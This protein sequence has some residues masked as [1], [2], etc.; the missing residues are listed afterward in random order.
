[1]KFLRRQFLHLAAGAAALPAV[2]RIAG[3]DT[4]P[5][6][7]VRI[8]VGVPAGGPIDLSARLIGQWLSDRL[9]EPFVVENKPSAAGNI[10]AETVAHAP[11]DGYTLLMAFASSAINAT[12]YE[13]LNYNFLR[14]IAPIASVNRIPLI[15]EVNPGLAVNTV[16][17]FIAYAKANPGKV[18]LATPGIGTAP[19]VAAELFRMMTGIDVVIVRYRGTPAAVTD[20]LSGQV[21]AMFDAVPTS[22]GHIK[23][24]KLRALAVATAGRL[25][26]L[27][28][29]PTVAETVAGFEAAGW[30]GVC[31]PRDTPAEII[32]KLNREINAGLVDPQLKA[33]LANLGAIP[34]AGSAAEFR[35]FIAD[36]TEK[37]AKVIRF[38][39]LKA[40]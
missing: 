4:Y 24:G 8:I 27:P 2:S 1:M 5:S 39:N 17:E 7:P 21:Q 18:N 33:R 26:V 28:E 10:G 32:D 23:S 30:A 34:F 35:R 31:A 9:G 20:V 22:I 19:D 36:E 37:W 38:A 6:R 13:N 15:L 40:E 16:A 12:L 25:E 11:P 3:A 29:V 14:D